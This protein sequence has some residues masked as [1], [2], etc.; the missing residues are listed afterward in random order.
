MVIKATGTVMNGYAKNMF[1]STW[2]MSPAFRREFGRNEVTPF[3]TR[4]GYRKVLIETDGQPTDLVVKA[5]GK[6]T[7]RVETDLNLQMRYVGEQPGVLPLF[8]LKYLSP[9][10][11]TM[12]KS[13]LDKALPEY[14]EIVVDVMPDKDQAGNY[15]SLVTKAVKQAREDMRIPGMAG[16]LFGAIGQIPSYLDRCSEDTGNA[17]HNGSRIFSV[18]YPEKLEG[19]YAG[20]IVAASSLFPAS[21]IMPKEEALL[22]TLEKELDEGRNVVILCAH[23]G[24]KNGTDLRM[25][26]LIKERFGNIAVILKSSAVKTGIRKQW[27]NEEVIDKGKRVLIANPVTIQTGLN[28]LVYFSTLMWLENPACNGTTYRQTCGRLHRPK[29]TLP[30]RSYFFVYQKTTQEL[31]RDLLGL[32]IA[33]ASQ[34]DGADMVTALNAAGAGDG[35]AIDSMELGRAIYDLIV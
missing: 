34:T 29:Q 22:D 20:S 1:R 26:R 3:V 32:K 13:D 6:Q 15:Q 25:A 9:Y 16:K 27:I 31:A 5:F 28:N 18:A 30:V 35:D 17:V 33:I 11:A 14:K 24:G 8:V 2:E 19:P 10:A 23:T 12:L 4:Y 7:D 21:R